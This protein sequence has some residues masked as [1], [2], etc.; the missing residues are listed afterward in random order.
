[1][2][3]IIH[4][5]V[6]STLQWAS[7]VLIAWVG[8]SALPL[9]VFW[10]APE[11]LFIEDGATDKPPL[12]L[13]ERRILRDVLMEYAVTVRSAPD[14]AVYCEARGGPF[15][16][17]KTAQYPEE[18]PNLEWWAPGCGSLPP[19]RYIVDTSW[20]AGDRWWG[21]LKAR[22]VSVTSNVFVVR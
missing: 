22:S 1:M 4:G 16:Y 10:F 5:R 15:W 19:G 18:P 17:R 20:T 2:K 8:L 3:W 9:P 7:L 12:V 13:F 11:R 21:I 6:A 14:F